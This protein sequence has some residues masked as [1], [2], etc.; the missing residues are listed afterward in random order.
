MRPEDNCPFTQTKVGEEDADEIKR[1]KCCR[2]FDWY[3]LDPC[4][5]C[6]EAELWIAGG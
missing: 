6:S 2:Q 3:W 5:E 1:L 4:E